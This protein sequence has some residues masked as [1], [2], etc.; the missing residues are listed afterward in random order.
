[1][2]N[3]SY[4]SANSNKRLDGLLCAV[5]SATYYKRVLESQNLE[6]D[7]Y[8]HCS[9]SCIVGI[10]C[11][12]S[13]SAVIGVAKEI[14]DLFGGGHAEWADLLANIHGLHLSQ[15]ADIQNFEDCSASCK[16]IY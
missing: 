12:V 11:G 2:M 7:K 4:A 14:Y 13:S 8:R 6:V 3:L 10:E 16:R 5:E 9:V 15:R 1:M